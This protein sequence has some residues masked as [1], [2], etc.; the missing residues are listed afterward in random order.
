MP[1]ASPPA[2]RSKTAFPETQAP[3]HKWIVAGIIL[4][5]CA[6]QIF[7]GTSLNV[8]IPR[9]MATFGTDL[10]ATQWVATGFLVTRTLVIPLLGL[11][12]AR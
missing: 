11:H 4:L 8:A 9:L 3:R 2:D 5:A 1:Q 12:L 6:A 7:A 10:A